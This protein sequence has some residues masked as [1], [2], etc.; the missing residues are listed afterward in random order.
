MGSLEVFLLIFSVFVLVGSCWFIV[1]PESAQK[2]IAWWLAMPRGIC[3][4]V[5]IA[6]IILG[7]AVV[8]EAIRRVKDVAIVAAV[9]VG[10]LLVVKGS[11]YFWKTGFVS[12]GTPFTAPHSTVWVRTAGVVGVLAV[13]LLIYL[14]IRGG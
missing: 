13:F 12:L 7:V 8:T 10:L 5:G 3:Y 4:A 11:I 6:Q 2:T 14:A 9:I 1:F